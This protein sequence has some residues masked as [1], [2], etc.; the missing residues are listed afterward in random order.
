[1]FNKGNFNF[2]FLII[3]CKLIREMHS[4][5][6]KVNKNRT[7]KTTKIS[8]SNKKCQFLYNYIRMVS[9]T[10]NNIFCVHTLQSID[11]VSSL[12]WS[13]LTLDELKTS[14]SLL[15]KRIG[16]IVN[17]TTFEWSL[18]LLKLKWFS[19]IIKFK[20]PE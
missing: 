12:T 18:G 2:H 20:I 5:E 9:A 1:M 10:M 8:F 17:I 14:Y 19:F 11:S 13:N 7:S 6:I 16:Y 3:I 15:Y 4:N